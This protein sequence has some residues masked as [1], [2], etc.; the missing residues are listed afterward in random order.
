MKCVSRFYTP[1]RCVKFSLALIFHVLVCWR[2]SIFRH[3]PKWVNLSNKLGNVIWCKTITPCTSRTFFFFI[4]HEA[5]IT[6]LGAN[7]SQGCCYTVLRHPPAHLLYLRSEGTNRKDQ[8]VIGLFSPLS[9]WH[10]QFS[11][12]GLLVLYIYIELATRALNAYWWS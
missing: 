10:I 12:V 8:W 5:N 2:V 11:E 7:F 6:T 3:L 9:L 1:E 4:C